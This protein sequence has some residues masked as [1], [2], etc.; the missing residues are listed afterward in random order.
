MSRGGAWAGATCIQVLVVFALWVSPGNAAEPPTQL[1]QVCPT[2]TAAGECLL[3]RGIAVSPVDGHVYLADSGNNRMIEFDAWGQFVRTFGWR[4]NKTKVELREDEEAH[5]EPVTVSESEENLCT[6]AQVEEGEECQAGAKASGVA[7]AAGRFRSPQGVAIDSAGNVFVVDTFNH[8]VDEFDSDGR[9]LAMIGKGVD[10]GGGS[11]AHPGD[12]CKAE[13]IADGDSCGAGEEGSEPGQLGAPHGGSYIAVDTR[14][15]KADDDDSLYVGDVGS[16]Q[17]CDDKMEGCEALPDPGG[18]LTGQTVQ[19]LAVVPSGSGAANAGWLFFTRAG[20]GLTTSLPNVFEIDATS[21]AKRC[22]A[23]TPEPTAL[24]AD[25]SGNLYVADGHK[26]ATLEMKVREFDSSCAEDAGGPFPGGALEG[27]TGLATGEVCLGEGAD[28]YIDNAPLGGANSFIRAYGPPPDKPE[29]AP[30]PAAP[31]I[32]AQWATSV[33][34]EDATLRAQINPHFWAG[35][36]GETDYRVQFAPSAC[37]KAKGWGAPCV[38]SQPNPLGTRLHSGVVSVPVATGTV[39]LSGL[40]SSTEYRYRFVASNTSPSP[41]GA[42]HP[43]YGVGG[44]P[45]VEGKDA[46]F[47]TFPVSEAGEMTCANQASR[48]GASAALPDCRA[49]ELVSPVDKEGGD[50]TVRGPT[51]LDQASVEGGKITYSSYRAF[52]GA[53][54]GPYSSQYIATRVGSGWHTE[55]IN[56]P[57]E[58][59]LFD[60]EPSLTASPFGAFT[61]DLAEAWLQTAS[62]PVLAPG[63]VTDYDNL[64]WRDNASGRYG[65]CTTSEPPN[66]LASEYAPEIEGAASDGSGSAVF[67]AEDKLTPDASAPPPIVRQLYE[68]RGGR[69]SLLSVLPD[70]LA[71]G[72]WNIAG[73]ANEFSTREGL[74][75]LAGA[76]SEDGDRVYWTATPG[77]SGPGALYVRIN[78]RAEES[79]RA[80][81][82]AA[83]AG[84]VV[85]P[86]GGIGSVHPT[87]LVSGVETTSGRFAVGQRITDAAGRIP[88]STII[89]AIEPE[90]GGK[91]RLTL[92]AAGTGTSTADSL[93]GLASETILNVSSKSGAFEEGQ[94]IGGFGIPTGTTVEACSPSCGASATSLTLSTKATRSEEDVPL[95]AT[96]ACTEPQNKACTMAVSASGSLVGSGDRHFWAATADGSEALFSQGD[97]LYRFELG[98]ALEGED[99]QQF[100]GG[101]VGLLGQSGD[102]SRVYFLTTEVISGPEVQMEGPMGTEAEE[103][104][105]NLYLYE[106]GEGGEEASYR[107]LATLTPRDASNATGRGFFSPAQSRPAKHTARVTPSGSTLAFMSNSGPLAEEVAGYDNTD[108]SSPAPC[109]QAGGICDAEIYRYDASGG[110]L[111]CVSCNPGGARPRGRELGEPGQGEEVGFFAPALLPTWETSLYARRPLSDT[112]NRLFFESYEPLVLS[113]TNGAA[114]VYEWEAPGTGS[115]SQ[116]SGRYVQSAE[117]CLYLI[118]SGKDPSDSEFIDATPDGSEAFFTTAQSLIEEDPG[119]TDLYDARID[120][121]FPPP[122]P[123]PAGC[124]GQACQAPAPAPQAK[125][126]ASAGFRGP[127]NLREKNPRKRCPKGR[128]AVRRHGKTRCVARR[129]KRHARHKH[130]HRGRAHARRRTGR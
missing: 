61:A 17:R 123:P 129:H 12:I 40:A 4:V 51:R 114:D 109:G 82:T 52:G 21:G 94:E 102:L 28:L 106:E 13:Y 105:P 11:P 33:G 50:V 25:A 72:K 79:H 14:S 27:S 86:A 90:T 100:A 31:E 15:T 59:Q 63:G 124:E 126:P 85:G 92:S 89:K 57:I 88:A 47:T 66:L 113:D 19:S 16:I 108:R 1:W 44:E 46:A 115:C 95:E 39:F 45:G 78:P 22:E 120:G 117:G 34:T 58:G 107:F 87:T 49:Y 68:C 73:T 20:S 6:Q 48:V 97:G 74:A 80:Q 101:F 127:G 99:P 128:R 23:A 77:E 60:I 93:T 55:A 104:D 119:S 54:S 26:T 67:G 43:V 53:V 24:A 29:C 84:D 38:K 121:G 96:S 103:G 62:E 130:R 70:G 81:G 3:P 98:E 125:T 76:T 69:V 35:E 30:P 112:G 56:P 122:P 83:G 37:I 8:R 111:A 2:G 7:A 41:G 91:L 116:E 71:S 5:S 32:D 18:L 9:F 65:A 118:S 110:K 36:F 64:Y 75:T 42:E 10:Q